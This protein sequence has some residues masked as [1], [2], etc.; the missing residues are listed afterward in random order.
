MA[1][2][3]VS[4]CGHWQLTLPHGG[5]LR[6]DEPSVLSECKPL[7]Y[8][9]RFRKNLDVELLGFSEHLC[10][11]LNPFPRCSYEAVV[12]FCTQSFGALERLCLV[13]KFCGLKKSL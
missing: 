11:K 12:V 5:E 7:R 9:G 1:S 3:S 2:W 4:H 10:P 13:R 8:S 6:L